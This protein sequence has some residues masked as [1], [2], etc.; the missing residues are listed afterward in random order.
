M[1]GHA[2]STIVTH[3][4]GRREGSAAIRLIIR[5]HGVIADGALSEIYRALKIERD[6]AV[7]FA[8]WKR[9]SEEEK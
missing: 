9:R 2:R 4:A 1:G 6:D 3:E 7:E 5:T 8:M